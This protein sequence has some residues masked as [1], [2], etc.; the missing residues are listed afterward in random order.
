MFNFE[1]FAAIIARSEELAWSV[2]ER[3]ECDF[4]FGDPIDSGEITSVC[5]EEDDYPDGT[6][7]FAD[8]CYMR[9]FDVVLC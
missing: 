3:K 9:L 7:H 8:Y 4:P 5:D 2:D 1:A 6:T